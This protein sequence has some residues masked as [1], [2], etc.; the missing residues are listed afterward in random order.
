MEWIGKELR[1]GGDGP[2]R[3]QDL[4]AT[5]V[6]LTPVAFLYTHTKEVSSDSNIRRLQLGMFTL[7]FAYHHSWRLR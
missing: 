6:L 7:H 1:E 4:I 2:R 5:V 3:R